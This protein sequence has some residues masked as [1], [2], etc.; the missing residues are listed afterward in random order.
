MNSELKQNLDD[1]TGVDADTRAQRRRMLKR[2]K[3]SF[4]DG[5]LTLDAL[6]K[7][8][9]DTGALLQIENFVVLPD[10]FVLHNELDGYK[11][12]CKVVW[13]NT[14]QLGVHFTSE[15]EQVEVLR[16][17]VVNMIYASAPIEDVKTPQADVI[18]IRRARPVQKSVF[19][20]R[21]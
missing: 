8:A 6:I 21:K 17:Q 7:N 15:I 18:N 4:R 3:I 2:V 14:T 9:S 12:P 16:T 19:G 1:L 13:R 10:E 20:I 5:F 11:V